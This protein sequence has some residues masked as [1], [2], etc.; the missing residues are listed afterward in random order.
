MMAAAAE[1][2][3]T[4]LARLAVGVVPAGPRAFTNLGSQAHEIEGIPL[5]YRIAATKL[6]GTVRIQGA[7]P[8]LCP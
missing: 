7:G 4:E 2:H 1:E 8:L 6:L 5:P 3:V